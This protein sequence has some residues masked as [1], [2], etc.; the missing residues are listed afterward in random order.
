MDNIL[1]I[2]DIDGTLIDSKGSGR[3]AMNEA[4]LHLFSVEDGFKDV[5][6]AGRLDSQIVK[7]AF[8]INK[9]CDTNFTRFLDKYEEMLKEGLKGN[10][11]SKVLPGINEILEK[12]ANNANIF[13]V[14]GTG[15]CERGARL[16]LSH[17]QLDKYFKIGGFGDEDVQRWQIIK[18][19]ISESE[20]FYDIDFSNNKTYVIGDTPLDIECGKILGI[21]SVAVATGGYSYDE[22]KSYEPDYIFQSFE[23][24]EE[25]LCILIK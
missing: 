9:I 21:K 3:N 10:T 22:L 19:A 7:Q 8:E 17:L 2:W 16:K 12:T 14:L 25:F 20:A 11:S 23:S 13:H 6:M 18:R 15:N 5:S 24:F 4:F 1:L